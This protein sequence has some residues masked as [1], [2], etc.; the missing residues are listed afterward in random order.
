MIGKTIS[1]YKILEKLGEGGMGV[2]YKAQDTK[3]DR[4]VALK[5]LPK[6]LLCDKEAKI[7]FEQ[8]AK[9][10]SSLNHPNITTIYEIDEIESECFIAMEYV[11]GKSLNELLK[12]KALS[13]KEILDIAIQICEGLLVAHEKGIVHRDIKSENIMLTSRGQVKIM[14]F[15]LAK[16]KG[17]TNLTKDGSTLGTAS[18]MSPEQ[19][20][21]EEVDNK[22]DIF[23]FGVV[24]Y[25]LLTK[26]LPFAGEHPAAI[27]Y[28][29]INEEPQPVVRYNNKVPPELERIVFKALAKDKEERYQHIDDLLADLR[30][31]KKSLEY[32]KITVTPKPAEPQKSAKKKTLPLVVAGLAVLIVIVGY[33][34]LFNKKEI[35]SGRKMLA[36]LPFENLGAPEQEYFASGITDEITTHLAKVSGL[37]VISRTSVLPYKNTKKTVQQIG[38]ELGVQYLLEGTILWDKSGVTN[39][40]RINPQLIRVKDGTHVWAE[41][42]DRVLEQIFALQSDIAEK[43]ASALNITLLEAE[44]RYIAAQP[45]KSLD[46]YEYYL[47]GNEYASRG[48][49]EKDNRIAIEMYEKAVEIDPTF[50][51]AY[52]N[53][54]VGHSA[55]YWFYYDRTS[56][57][58]KKAK[59]TVD[60]AL[61]L[62]PDLPEAHWALGIYYYFGS[63]DYESALEQFA[64]G[65][66]GQPNNSDLFAAIGY[67]QRRQGKFLQAV[68][69]LKKAF[70]LDPRSYDKAEETATTYRVMRKYAEAENYLDR[71]I[72]LAP[73]WLRAYSD[74][75]WL[76]VVSEGETKKAREVL[77]E[78]TGKVDV[79]QLVPDLVRLDIFDG[80]YQTALGRLAGL[81]TLA[82]L[83]G[84]N[85]TISYFLTKAKI[86]GL[87]NQPKSKLACYDSTRVILENKVKSR[88]SEAPFHSDLGIAYAGLGRKEEAIQEGKKGVEL[89][90]VSKDALAGLTYVQNLA[91][92]YVMVG[93]YDSAVDQLEYFLS[94]P[95]AI[96]IPY[97]R[98][99]P[100]WAPL[101]NHP[102][103]KKLLARNK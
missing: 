83:S 98:I 78:A 20:K 67:V 66:K 102:G 34:A 64:I 42:Y 25:E 82:D 8:E 13:L 16:L 99:D 17:V 81:T 5:F 85:D 24:L 12:E 11:E 40:V 51:I 23:S 3:L 26:Q 45:T 97:L 69:N 7:R 95:S 55:R 10:A 53:L 89:L 92:I 86:Y 18:Y 62:N 19:A 44:Q 60:R 74:K 43:V 54:S 41:T 96:S 59:E 103:F 73:D 87:L 50:A 72:S 80:E 76:Y 31:E 21:G 65:Q 52:A 32:V 22:S 77:Q 91:Q 48:G 56:E 29:I 71:A 4:T 9:A 58:L 46:A 2:V 101:R 37:G 28:S 57:R 70:E 79:S 47:R 84:Y 14:D 61:E 75:A 88:P 49:A 15:G 27:I 6:N 94:I 33:F 38:K 35:E 30:R 63:R 36:V 93:D 100:T 90:P 39:R 68:T 1:H